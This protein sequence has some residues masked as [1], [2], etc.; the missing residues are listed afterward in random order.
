M[1][2]IFILKRSAFRDTY[3]I[4]HLY[5][6]DGTYFCDTLEDKDRKLTSDMPLADIKKIK[7]YGQT[8]IP[9]GKYR[10]TIFYWQKYQN[11]YPLLNNV[12][13]F[14]GILIHGG[15]SDIDTLG[16]VLLGENKIVGKLINCSKYVRSITKKIQDYIAQGDKVFIQIIK[17]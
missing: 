15:H 14:S 6:P 11:N 10:L 5:N 4:G 13:A 8:A 7:I 12:P 3:T 17:K 16:C 1:E 2:Q 9:C